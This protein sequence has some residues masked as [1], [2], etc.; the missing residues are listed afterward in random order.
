[1]WKQILTTAKTLFLLDEKTKR[2]HEEIQ[3][4]RKEVR[5][6]TTAVER[7]AYEIHRVDE[8]ARHEREKLALRL[9]NELLRFE[10]RLS[11]RGE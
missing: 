5:D 4:I 8:N 7:L 11:A 3:E 10:R 9:D 1:M 2:N 6:L